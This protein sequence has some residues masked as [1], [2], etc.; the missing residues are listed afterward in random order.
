MLPPQ[1]KDSI[2]Y[3]KKTRNINTFSNLP[4]SADRLNTSDRVQ[5]LS[6]LLYRCRGSDTQ[7]SEHL[8]LNEGRYQNSVEQAVCLVCTTMLS[9]DTTLQHATPYLVAMPGMFALE[10]RSE[11]HRL[12]PPGL[13][14]PE[15]NHQQSFFH[16]KGMPVYVIH[17]QWKDTEVLLPM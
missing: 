10:S 4:V 12:L 8:K 1:Y 15:I 13:N 9:A 11:E 2:V 3:I 16:P 17:L 7:S 5:D 14:V 6:A